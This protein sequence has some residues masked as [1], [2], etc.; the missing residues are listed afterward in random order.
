MPVQQRPPLFPQ[1]NGKKLDSTRYSISLK[2]SIERKSK[3]LSPLDREEYSRN[4]GGRENFYKTSPQTPVARK[5]QNFIN[6]IDIYQSSIPIVKHESLPR[7]SKLKTKD[8]LCNSFSSKYGV[9]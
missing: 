4:C 8:K 1:I 6:P 5:K 7:R 9:L 3:L 2:S